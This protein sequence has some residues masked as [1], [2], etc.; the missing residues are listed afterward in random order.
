MKTHFLSIQLVTLQRKFSF[1]FVLPLKS[2]HYTFQ[3]TPFLLFLNI[4]FTFRER[5]RG[6]EETAMCKRH[7]NWLPLTRPQLG[8]GPARK[9][10]TCPD[11]E[12]KWRPFNSQ[13]ALNPLS[14]ISQ[15][16]FFLLTL[17]ITS[18]PVILL[19]PTQPTHTDETSTWK[20]MPSPTIRADHY[21]LSIP[22]TIKAFKTL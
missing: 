12:S 18:M 3:I 19:L 13:A 15:G 5:G 11:W 16:G 4:L 10:D 7:I 9:P 8:T 17:F 22:I 1:S 21:F 6:E 20:L 2:M 14:H